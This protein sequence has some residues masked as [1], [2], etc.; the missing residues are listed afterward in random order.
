VLIQA[1]GRI[2][3]R[4]QVFYDVFRVEKG[5]IAEQWSVSQPIPDAMPHANGML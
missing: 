3:G 4:P 5:Q 2:D 1:E